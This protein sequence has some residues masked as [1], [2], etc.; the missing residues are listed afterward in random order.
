MELSQQSLE[1]LNAQVKIEA[2]ASHQYLATAAW[3]ESQP[4]LDGVTEFF[5]KQ[6]QEEREHMTRLMHYIAM[7]KGKAVVTELAKPKTQFKDLKEVFESFLKNEQEVTKSINKWVGLALK[8]EDYITFQFWQWYLKEQLEEE[9][10]ASKMLD[11]LC[12]IGND[13]GALYSFD[14]DILR[15]REKVAEDTSEELKHD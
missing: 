9:N 15:V 4:G 3:L 8:E 11:E 5:Y 1:A 6:S 13:K 10:Q 12:I 7:R 14:K 2:D